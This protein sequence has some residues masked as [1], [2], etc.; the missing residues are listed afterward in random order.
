MATPPRYRILN[1]DRFDGTTPLATDWTPDGNNAEP[2][3]SV[4]QEVIGRLSFR[5][6]ARPGTSGLLLMAR[7][8]GPAGSGSDT[9]TV[10]SMNSTEAAQLTVPDDPTAIS[11]DQSLEARNLL[12]TWS[13]PAF[14]GPTDA[15]SLNW[16]PQGGGTVELEMAEIQDALL[17]AKVA[18]LV[19]TQN[20][21]DF[22][23]RTIT[24]STTL[25][26]WSKTLY[27][28]VQ[29]PGGATVSLPDLA[30]VPEIGTRVVY[31]QDEG[32]AT[33][34]VD[35]G[36]TI[37][38]QAEFVSPLGSMGIIERTPFGWAATGIAESSAATTLSNA[39][40]GS[41]VAVPEWTGTHLFMVDF[42][43]RGVLRLPAAADIGVD[44]EAIFVRTGAD[45]GTHEEQAGIL[46]SGTEEI[47][48]VNGPIYLGLIGSSVRVK[49]RIDGGWIATSHNAVRNTVE[50]GNKTF[51]SGWPGRRTVVTTA[52]GATVTLPPYDGI[53]FPADCELEVLNTGGAAA[54]VQR[55]NAA[56]SVVGGGAAGANKSVASNTAG[57]FRF[58]GTAWASQVV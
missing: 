12:T 16:L 13:S 32:S 30:D 2:R 41:A 18:A 37:N 6:L 49:R 58:A 17:A 11:L 53:P 48:H 1:A 20:S 26:G 29:T 5:D 36:G 4:T 40:A 23:S 55:A 38:G 7:R 47:N 10:R 46:P 35:G 27:L 8:W 57:V 19:A 21:N 25:A 15:V 43:A 33:F 31:I 45:D 22:S 56:E 28:L 51:T 9:L 34:N 42:T 54:T 39:V 44:A 50:A 14:L 24:A 3:A 52:A